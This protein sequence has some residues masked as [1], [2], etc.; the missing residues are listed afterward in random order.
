M[1]YYFG[2]GSNMNMAS[3]KAK[4]VEP[5]SSCR[6]ELK[7]WRLR[8]NVQHFFRHEG[9]VANIEYT[10]IPGDRVLGV[11]HQCQ[12]EA[13]PY[14]DDAEAYGFGYDRIEVTLARQANG[15]PVKA[16]TY[17]GMPAFINDQCRPSQRYLNIVS[18]GAKEAGLDEAYVQALRAQPIHQNAPYPKFTPPKGSYPSF[19]ASKLASTPNHT[20]LYGHVFDMTNARPTHEFLKGFFGG[21]D[22]TLF[23][24]KRMDS[25]TQDESLEAI[26]QGQL[27][28]SQQEYLNAYLHEYDREYRYVGHF[29]YDPE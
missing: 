16:L 28:H 3:L 21:K 23:H 19:C 1:F 6:A 10:G 13:L 9:G 12:Q 7:G 14:L 27:N 2:F 20:A 17:V 29:S 11:V 25:S 8:F 18:Q 5:L 24:L 15:Q 22:M 4:G 26:R